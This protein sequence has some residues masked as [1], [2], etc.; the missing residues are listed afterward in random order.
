MILTIL[1][2]KI[3]LN[4]KNTIKVNLFSVF[5][6]K[7]SIRYL[8]FSIYEINE[9]LLF[10]DYFIEENIL[11]V[12]GNE[13]REVSPCV[14]NF[15]DSLKNNEI[16]IENRSFF[17][18]FNLN[19]E[20]THKLYIDSFLNDLPAQEILELNMKNK[21]CYKTVLERKNRIEIVSLLKKLK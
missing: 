5:I 11:G 6:E 18:I 19:I 17:F 1:S 16:V 2:K 10:S 14:Q 21:I 13:T 9:S 7:Y 8:F 12:F 15:R 4:E 3:L 20:K